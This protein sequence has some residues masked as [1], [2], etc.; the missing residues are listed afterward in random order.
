M[1]QRCTPAKSNETNSVPKTGTSV[2]L[3]LVV[4]L[5][6]VRELELTECRVQVSEFARQGAQPH[7]AP[8][9]AQPLL[10]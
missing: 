7:C 9:H 1:V 6:V 2:K 5:E 8:P 10:S 3:R 4:T